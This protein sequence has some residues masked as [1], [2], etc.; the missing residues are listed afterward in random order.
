MERSGE[1]AYTQSS[2]VDFTKLSYTFTIFTY[3]KAA[4]PAG[5]PSIGGFQIEDKMNDMTFCIWGRGSVSFNSR[6]NRRQ[7]R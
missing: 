7:N 5:K 1:L 2:T 4:S 6:Y 3:K